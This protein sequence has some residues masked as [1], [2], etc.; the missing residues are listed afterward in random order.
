MTQTANAQSTPTPAGAQ[1]RVI[2]AS[3][4]SELGDRAVFEALRHCAHQP[5]STLFVITVGSEANSGVRLPGPETRVLPFT[6]AQEAARLRVAQIVDNYRSRGL[7]L[8]M[9]QIV[10]YVVTGSPAE[11]IVALATALDADLIVLGTHGRHG[12]SRVFLGSVATEVVERAPCGVFVI[13][14]REFLL[15][16]KLPEVEP[17]LQQGEHALLPFRESA[18]YHHI[19]RDEAETTRIMPA[20]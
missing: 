15:G 10:V 12:L 13:R 2:A 4:F 3:D 11:R 7:Q 17:P 1:Y 18:T 20:I 5:G 9:D 16:E 6:D 19:D 8:P 14:P